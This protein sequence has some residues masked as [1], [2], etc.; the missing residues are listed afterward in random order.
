MNRPF[1]SKSCEMENL[2]HD[3]THAR[4]RART[5]DQLECSLPVELDPVFPTVDRL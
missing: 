4:T 1:V 3:R 5:A 2:R